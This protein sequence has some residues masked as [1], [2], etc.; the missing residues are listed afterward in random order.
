MNFP[1]LIF[2]FWFLTLK[3]NC[4][5]EGISKNE[6]ESPQGL[7]GNPKFNHSY[8][9]KNLDIKQIPNISGP[10]NS[11]LENEIKIQK[12]IKSNKLNIFNFSEP[13]L[14]KLEKLIQIKS[15]NNYAYK[16]KAV[17]MEPSISLIENEFE[18]ND[19]LFKRKLTST[20]GF[21]LSEI[22]PLFGD[23][24]KVIKIPFENKFESKRLK[25]FLPGY[26]SFHGE[27]AHNNQFYQHNKSSSDFL[28]Q[29]KG[30]DI[31]DFKKWIEKE[32]KVSRLERFKQLHEE[33]SKL[34]NQKVH[35]HDFEDLHM[36][37]NTRHIAKLE[38]AIKQIE[39]EEEQRKLKNR[40]EL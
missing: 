24:A 20:N 33:F 12:M 11:Y 38:I 1:I 5:D 30:A 17:K 14:N 8:Y 34:G 13:S 25:V 10:S 35:E 3:I 36:T 32:S 21:N 6:L 22:G 23:L 31:N 18:R 15:K 39:L 9:R 26:E 40:Q 27:I 2:N 7:H 28:T 16:N 19:P 37:P 4:D 29:G